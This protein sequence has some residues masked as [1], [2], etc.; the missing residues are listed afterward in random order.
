M[1]RPLCRLASWPKGMTVPSIAPSRWETKWFMESV[2]VRMASG[3]RKPPDSSNSRI[4]GLTPPAR[5][6]NKKGGRLAAASVRRS[7]VTP[8]A[9]WFASCC[10]G[11]IRSRLAALGAEAAVR[12]DLDGAERLFVPGDHHAKH[13]GQFLGRHE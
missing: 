10:S 6:L 11:L 3:R 9:D 5:R 12:V 4:R 1:G 2:S 13:L 7:A 8:S